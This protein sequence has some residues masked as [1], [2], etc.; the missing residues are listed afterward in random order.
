MEIRALNDQAQYAQATG[1]VTEFERLKQEIKKLQNE[2][3]FKQA[4]LNKELATLGSTA[5]ARD[6]ESA[7]KAKDRA[8]QERRARMGFDARAESGGG[9][10]Q[11]AELKALQ[12]SLK[13]QLDIAQ[14]TFNKAEIS[15][16]NADLAKVN[17]AIAKMAGLDTMSTAPGAQGPSGT[18]PPLSSFQ[19]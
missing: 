7:D 19:R 14:K 12:T 5:R 18:R 2:Y 9:K 15:K 16:I 1:N 17:A 11:L 6:T 13:G 4:D 3:T 10:Q 8:S